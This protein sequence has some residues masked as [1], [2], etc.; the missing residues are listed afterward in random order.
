MGMLPKGSKC[1]SKQQKRDIAR[2]GNLFN[3]RDVLMVF[4]GLMNNAR[5]KTLIYKLTSARVPIHTN[6]IE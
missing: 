6:C 2:L 1:H 5:R 4:N 3:V